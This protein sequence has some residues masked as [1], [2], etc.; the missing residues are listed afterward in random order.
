MSPRT[1]YQRGLPF[2]LG[3]PG[4]TA[5][6]R[7]PPKKSLAETARDAI[8]LYLLGL[9]YCHGTPTE[10]DLQEARR[11]HAIAAERGVVDAQ[12][13][14]SLLLQQGVGGKRDAR[15][16]AQWEA[17]AAQAGHPR[18]CLNR[19]ARAANRKCPDYAGAA[20]WYERA[21]EAGNAEAA[22]R[23]GRMHLAGQGVERDETIARRWFERAAALGY[24]WTSRS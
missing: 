21:A 8:K 22:A 19:G 9:A 1:H 24:D 16:A 13:E 10:Q 12:F 17:R 3:G 7:G 4:T 15:A 6:G 14:L 20:L 11:L 5:R 18:A 2:A 23:L